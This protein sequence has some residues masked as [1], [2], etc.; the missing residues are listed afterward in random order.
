MFKFYIYST[1]QYGPVREQ[2]VTCNGYMT[3]LLKSS[4]AIL[5]LDMRSRILDRTAPARSA[6]VSP[7]E[8]PRPPRPA[9]A[10]PCD[11]TLP[12]DN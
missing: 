1:A 7:H 2:C 9:S 10:P 8:T 5:C 6:P 3:R 4:T 11:A 12:N